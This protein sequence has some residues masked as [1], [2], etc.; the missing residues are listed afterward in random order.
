[1]RHPIALGL[2]LVGSFGCGGATQGSGPVDAG[3]G[4]SNGDASIDASHVVALTDGG[5]EARV[6]ID[7][8]SAA[9]M[10]VASNY[11]QSCAVDTDCAIVGTG[12][13]CE[14]NQCYC[15]GS[16]I[17]ANAVPQF[18]ADVAKTPVGMG[19]VPSGNCGCPFE[20][21]PCCAGG[22]CQTGGACTSVMGAD[23]AANDASGYTPDYTVLCVED[24]GPADGGPADAPAIPGVSRWCNGAEQCV[25]FNG[26]W[27]CCVLMNGI[28]FCVAP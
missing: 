8:D 6:D 11:D 28:S 22:K 23:A 4:D 2:L 5:Q 9:C 20:G 24:A 26:G 27:D 17:N 15:G 13:Y 3:K 21:P 25:P 14:A 19:D 18:Q 12:N 10:L 1:V 7:V 16:S